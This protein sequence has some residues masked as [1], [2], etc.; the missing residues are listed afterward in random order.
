MIFRSLI[1]M[2]LMIVSLACLAS[3]PTDNEVIAKVKGANV[4][5]IELNK[6][7]GSFVTKKL[8]PWWIRSLTYKVSAG[9]KEFPSAMVKVG[10]EARYR[11]LG[12]KFV[13]DEL[14]T[15]WNEYEGI[16]LP[17]DSQILGI[18]K[19]D[20]IKLV[21]VYNWNKMVS[22]FDG[23]VLSKD[24]ALR[25][26]EWHAAN[27]FSIHVQG[28]YS[29]ISSYTDV[30]DKRVDFAVRF[31][32]DAVNKP[33][34]PYFVSSVSREDLIATHKYTSDEI[35][36]MPTQA[37]IAAEKKAQAEVSGL[38]KVDVPV[39]K[40]DREALA[41]IYNQLRS[42]NKK[43]V[44]SL[45]RTMISSRYYVPGS[46]VQLSNQGRALL[47]S[48]LQKM[49]DG[50][51]TF[52]ETYCPQL[53]VQK[54]QQNQVYVVDAL[55]KN[56]SRIAVSLEG[57]RF[58]RGKKVGQV[59]KIKAI[60][61][62]VLRAA[63]DIAQFKSWP[64]DELCADTAK[65][66]KP[67]SVSPIPS[68]RTVQQQP[69]A[70]S[71]SPVASTK[72]PS[73]VQFKSKYLPVSMKVIGKPSENQ[74]MANGKLNT[75]M[76]AKSNDGIF[77]MIATDYK[78][79]ISPQIANPTH[80]QFAKNFVKSNRAKVHSKKVVKFATG[81]AQE[82]LIERGSGA[83]KM[84]VN[85]RIFSHGTVVYQVVYSQLKSAF[86]KTISQKFMDSISI[87]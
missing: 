42:G 10:A 56:K 47:K 28:K 50:K 82:Y 26:V 30:Q 21:G 36:A 32:R 60:E 66:F 52:S 78:Q 63:Q 86:D 44:E 79:K 3:K 75:T 81:N 55:K 64:F 14:K 80:I 83:Q 16:P 17:K 13:F 19:N 58:E 12:E 29:L 62:W 1:T 65:T 33:W 27:S 76:M 37:S 38:P 31:Y 11:I 7:G 59:Y 43:Q 71:T 54:Y 4:S 34:K 85:F 41:F 46:K 53:L 35:N 68:N 25:R 23:P 40:N 77:Q 6:Q 67:L 74:K 18:L 22:E 48:T 87:R 61:L 20:I 8:Q 70:R 51:V 49:F 69:T 84:M 72:T 24:P 45:F 9:L 73:W 57:G 15:L 39:F 5:N 2:G